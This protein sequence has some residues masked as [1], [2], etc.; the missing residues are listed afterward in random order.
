MLEK[1]DPEKELRKWREARAQK[2]GTRQTPSD[3]RTVRVNGQ[4]VVVIT[5]PKRA[6]A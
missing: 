6:L 4:E 5:K 1:Y 3:R 2:R